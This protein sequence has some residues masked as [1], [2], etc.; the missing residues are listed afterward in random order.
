[1]KE[2]IKE[3][4]KKIPIFKQI[5]EWRMFKRDIKNLYQKASLMSKTVKKL[6]KEKDDL[7][8][9]IEE[10]NKDI[11]VK[12]N[13]IVYCEK[14]LKVIK[15]ELDN[16]INKN[17]K[18]K[19]QLISYESKIDNFISMF[20]NKIKIN[21]NEHNQIRKNMIYNYYASIENNKYRREIELRYKNIMGKPIDL[22]NPVTYCEK[23]QWLKLYDSTELKTRLSDKL[24]VRDW[25]KEKIGEKYLI[26][27]I[28]SWEDFD[29]IDFS[30]FPNKFAIKANH[31]CGYN[32]I[33]KNKEVFDI[34]TAKLKFKRWLST[35]FAFNSLEIH[36]KNIKPM[37]LAEEYLENYDDDLYDYKVWCFNGKAEY[38]MFLADRNNELKMVFYDREWNKM[39]FVYSHPQ[40][41]NDVKRPDNLEEMLEISEKL[42]EGF[43]HVRVDFYRLN[44]G[45]LKFGE[46]TFTSASGICEWNP[47]KYD[48]ILG[49]MIIL[50]KKSKFEGQYL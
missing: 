24:L 46:M 49:D 8:Y 41:E 16:E 3:F 40:Y 39:P 14:E 6:E 50:P 34:D 42:A 33:V 23:I 18:L 2:K 19:E 26:P 29:D 31:G 48:K 27:L 10:I 44:D 22:D 9:K 20:E 5:H 11:E 38:I 7:Y 43:A 15:E 21:N 13:K 47:P 37:I 25:V 30:A 12:K 4:L 1:M 17:Y 36:Y 35:N 28:G 45:T 32:L